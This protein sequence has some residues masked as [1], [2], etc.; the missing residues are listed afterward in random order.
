MLSSH[1]SSILH[2]VAKWLTRSQPLACLSHSAIHL[3]AHRWLYCA[4]RFSIKLFSCRN[5]DMPEVVNLLSNRLC[6]SSAT[7]KKSSSGENI[8]IGARSSACEFSPIRGALV[9]ADGPWHTLGCA[10]LLNIIRQRPGL[11]SGRCLEIM[12]EYMIAVPPLKIWSSCKYL[13][14]SLKM[15]HTRKTAFFFFFGYF[16]ITETVVPATVVSFPL[17]PDS[18]F[19][20]AMMKSFS[21][22]F[23]SGWVRP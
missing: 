7:H 14:T 6:Q 10:K 20:S 8:L 21:L 4:A 9:G 22:S 23:T 5:C 1:S 11:K 15:A 19:P 18:S 12:L 16:Y 3:S 13:P 2:L 17:S